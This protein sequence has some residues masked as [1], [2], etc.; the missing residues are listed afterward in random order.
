MNFT[1]T[2]EL[3]HHGILGMKW[4]VRRYQNKDG[5]LTPAGKKKLSSYKSK[6]LDLSNKKHAKINSK[7]LNKYNKRVYK[8]HKAEDR[9]GVNSSRYRK[10]EKKANKAYANMLNATEIADKEIKAIKSMKYSDMKREK[11]LVGEHVAGSILMSVGSV[12]L[13]EAGYSPFA[14]IS[15]PDPDSYKT[16]IRVSR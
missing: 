6:E 16:A 8:L 3:Y 7:M 11:R 1:Y 13:M 4:G 15:V 12:T 5:S 10:L 9:Y 14:I 2:D